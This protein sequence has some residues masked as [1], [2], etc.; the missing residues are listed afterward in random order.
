MKANFILVLILF[1]IPIFTLQAAE[2]FDVKFTS[3]NVQKK[4]VINKPYAVSIVVKN[5]GSEFWSQ[6]NNIVLMGTKNS[7]KIWAIDPIGLNKNELVKPGES[8]QYKFRIRSARSAGIYSLQFEMRQNGKPFGEKS[9]VA[10]IVV[11]T[12]SNRVKFISQL[13]PNSMVGGQEYS[14]A[15]QFKNNGS[16]VWTRENGYKLGNKSEKNVWD[17]SVVK[18]S[19]SDIIPPGEIA[20][21]RF[22]LKAPEKP[23]VYPVQWQMKKGRRWFGEPTPAQ[24]VIVKQSNSS[25]G[26]EFVYQKIP[27]LKQSNQAFSIFEIGNIY[28]V[29][30]TFKNTS[31]KNWTKGRF[32]L[33]PQNPKGNMHWSV[34]RIELKKNEIVKPGEMKTFNFKVIAPLQPGIYNFQ[35]Q[36]VEGFNSV[37]G[38]K[39]ENI[40]VTVK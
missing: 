30:L 8:K 22:K 18:L 17:L 19:S 23:G 24:Q 7:N 20:T 32:S 39:S 26:A 27:G 2:E 31:D 33:H 37:I 1:L 11:E 40:S 29:T 15:V 36:M 38:E 25:K 3:V 14:I 28:P 21:F 12:R 6:K 9:K 13:M 10:N 35:W 4:M 16:S 5:T 34:D